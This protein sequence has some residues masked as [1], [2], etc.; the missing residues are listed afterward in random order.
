MCEIIYPEGN[1]D[2]SLPLH[3]GAGPVFFG[4]QDLQK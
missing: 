2:I 3:N 4:S 1:K